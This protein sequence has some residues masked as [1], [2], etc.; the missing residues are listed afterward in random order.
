MKMHLGETGLK[1][2]KDMWSAGLIE[3]WS[4]EEVT[5]HSLPI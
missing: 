2:K 5:V 1:G 3:K 4:K